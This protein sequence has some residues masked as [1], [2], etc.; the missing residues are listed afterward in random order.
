[1]ITIHFLFPSSTLTR[2]QI[3]Y[4]L[5]DNRNVI[6]GHYTLFMM[7]MVGLRI[8]LHY[9]NSRRVSLILLYHHIFKLV[10]YSNDDSCPVYYK[11]NDFVYCAFELDF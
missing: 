10:L 8:T 5:R 7:L 4:D 6:N 1:M 2:I 3:A 11:P 9:K